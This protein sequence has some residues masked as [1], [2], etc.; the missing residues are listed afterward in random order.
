MSIHFIISPIR[1]LDFIF[2]DC[3]Y[4]ICSMEDPNISGL[5]VLVLNFLDVGDNHP[6]S[7]NA[8]DANA[9]INFVNDAIKRNI[10]DIYML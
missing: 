9:I 6:Y 10:S 1:G 5:N 2:D 4:I 8:E 3:A 7:F